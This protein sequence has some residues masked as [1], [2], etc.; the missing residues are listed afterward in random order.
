MANVF[1]PAQKQAGQ[2]PV[3][4]QLVLPVRVPL[5]QPELVQVPVVPAVLALPGQGLLRVQAPVALRV[6]ELPAPAALP[7]L[8]VPVQSQEL[9]FP[10]PVLPVQ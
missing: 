10:Q 1:H 3:P 2:T 7:R 8:P 9:L 5:S 4:P 6:P